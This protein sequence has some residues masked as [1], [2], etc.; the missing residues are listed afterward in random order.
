MITLRCLRYIWKRS[1]WWAK[2]L[3]EQKS[4]KDFLFPNMPNVLRSPFYI[5]CS[6]EPRFRNSQVCFGTKDFFCGPCRTNL[7]ELP[8]EVPIELPTEVPTGSIK[9]I[10]FIEIM[11]SMSEQ[12]KWGS[13]VVESLQPLFYPHHHRCHHCH[14]QLCHQCHHHHQCHQCHHHRCH[15]CDHQSGSSRC[16]KVVQAWQ[17]TSATVQFEIYWGIPYTSRR[18]IIYCILYLQYKQYC[19]IQCSI[20]CLQYNIHDTVQFE[21]Y[22]GWYQDTA[23]MQLISYNNRP[24]HGYWLHCCAVH[25]ILIQSFLGSHHSVYSITPIGLLRLEAPTP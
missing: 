14:H 24:H 17:Q 12:V 23:A 4:N 9:N 15:H 5:L 10:I 2:N 19:N 11:M 18:Y 20:L 22:W 6:V 21:I 8:T 25:F 7:I 1:S 13:K 16:M 3:D